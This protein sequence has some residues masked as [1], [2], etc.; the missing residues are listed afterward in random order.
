MKYLLLV[1]LTCT[2][3]ACDKKESGEVKS[4]QTQASVPTA[5]STHKG[6]SLSDEDL[7]RM[8]QRMVD[9]MKSATKE[10]VEDI[11]KLDPSMFKIEYKFNEY[12]TEYY[13][14]GQLILVRGKSRPSLFFLYRN[15]KEFADV[16]TQK[17]WSPRIDL[18]PDIGFRA[19]LSPL[20]E[21]AWTLTTFDGDPEFI[22]LYIIT[23]DE[24]LPANAEVYLQY[25]AF[26][27]GVHAAFKTMKDSMLR[28]FS[29]SDGDDTK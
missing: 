19:S 22:E 24:V 6:K 8:M 7:N 12:G 17:D 25:Y 29:D 1:L 23:R 16:V 21:G 26:V 10:S 15:G 18:Q 5:E 3:F 28:D 9:E 11:S 27:K 20:G 14:R 2:C 4:D 13:R